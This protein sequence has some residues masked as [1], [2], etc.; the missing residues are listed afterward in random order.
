MVSQK[1]SYLLTYRE[2]AEILGLRENTL[3]VWVSSGKIPHVKLGS[4]V[5]FTPEMVEQII[6][7]STREAIT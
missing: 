1:N 5:R 6:A 4:A 2:V 7:Q 3:R